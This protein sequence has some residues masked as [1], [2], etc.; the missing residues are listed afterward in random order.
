MYPLRSCLNNS[1]LLCISCL[2]SIFQPRS[3]KH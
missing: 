2:L 1:R 3:L